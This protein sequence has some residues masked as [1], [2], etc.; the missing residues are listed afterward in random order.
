MKNYIGIDLGTTNSAI[1]SYDGEDVRLWKSPEQND[2]TPSVIYIDKRGNKYVGRRAYDAAPL[3]PDSVAS[4]FK[5]FMGTST[6]I[7]LK[8]SDST[9]TPEECSAEVLRVL[10]GYLPEEVR[11][12]DDTGTVITVPAAFNQMQKDATMKAAEL[13]GIGRV[14]LMQ[15]P[16]AAVMSVMR[17][18]DA[19]GTF[20]VFDL[21]GGTLDVAVAESMSGRVNLLAH[22]GIAVC[23][24]RDWDR[25]L[26]DSVVKPW[27]LD[28]FDLPD[29]FSANSK[30]MPLVRMASW[31]A[32]KAKIELSS[33]EDSMISL[34]EAETRVSD[35]SGEE[36]YLEIPLDR[37]TLDGLIEKRID[38]A[39]GAARDTLSKAGMTANDV[40]RVVFVGG[41]THYKPLRDK[42]AFELGVPGSTEVNPMTAVSEGAAVFAESVEWG[43]QSKGR[44]SNRGKVSSTGAISVAFNYIARTPDNKAKIA[45]QLT[46]EV[47]D[48]A[49]FQIDNLD[50]GWSSGR[51]ALVDGKITEVSLSKNGEN[52]FKVFV[53]D[54]DGGP[55]TLG[56]DRLV[57]T[58]TAATVEAIPASY[59][60]GIEVLEKL[61]GRASLDWL[62]RA[63]DQLPVKGTRTYKA[64]ESLK[65][66]SAG[67]INFKVWEGEIEDPVEDNRFIGVF[68]I[69]GSDFDQGVIPAGAS[70]E[71]NYE[72]QDSGHIV[73]GVD[74][75]EIG[76]VF[77]A[78]QS[79][80]SRQEGEIDF[81]GDSKRILDDSESVM[82][83]LDDVSTVCD[84]PKVEQA[85]QKLASASQ[86]RLNDGD[87][88]TAQEAM[89]SVLEAKRL[90]AK[91]RKENAKQIR[92]LDLDRSKEFFDGFVR[93]F[94]RPSEETAFDSLVRTAQRD[95]DRNSAGFETHL[96]EM[97]NKI[98]EILWRQDWFLI[99]R[100]NEMAKS[101]HLFSDVSKH[102]ELVQ[103]GQ[104]CLESDDIENLRAVMAALAAI[105]IYTSTETDMLDMANIV[106]G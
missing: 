77:A 29:D 6:P 64:T 62:V 32:E 47:L 22:G 59:S 54:A 69:S 2:V 51:M 55:V 94:A 95:I 46:D 83:R 90:L 56:E 11:N 38:E 76:G 36:I 72:I 57:V 58:R 80:Y 3:N 21:G 81:H 106:R 20:V 28:K 86:D 19:D 44:K 99:H 74:V 39:V 35:E 105:Q 61:G 98:S 66:G 41:P 67:V 68:K 84:D 70:L 27:L 50:T 37:P 49:E 7:Q 91:V 43:S 53:F 63:G 13:A 25:S 79:F 52:T 103:T 85:R 97:R 102:E 23:G 17:A 10:F 24:G 33:R 48:G 14:A 5:R 71:L 104:R 4:L 1:S 34:T 45:V 73:I 30:Y 92:Q 12:D 78:G 60:I 26:V 100:F 18:K 42:V 89:E 8:A 93:E 40:E 65:A 101:P 9:W 96:D 87:A 15:E 82:Q 75:P 88:E 31:A 16:V